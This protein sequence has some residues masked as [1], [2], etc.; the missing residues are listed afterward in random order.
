M[1]RQ[2][3]FER[4]DFTYEEKQAISAKSD[5][6]CCHCG[7]LK[8]I[9]YGATVD[10]FVPLHKGGSNQMINLV[11]LCDDC[12]QA[13]GSKI[14]PV[15][16]LP[17]LKPKYQEEL[18]GYLDSYIRSFEYIGRKQL[19]ACD[20]YDVVLLNETA[21]LASK[22]KSHAKK[23]MK[24]GPLGTK[25][26]IKIAKMDDFVKICDYYEKYLKKYGVFNSR[27]AVEANIHFWMRFGCIYYMEKAG[28]VSVMTVF[29]VKHVTNLTRSF[30]G[31]D[32]GL[33]M[34]IFSYYANEQAFSIASNIVQKFPQYIMEEQDLKLMPVFINLL[35]DDKLTG[36][37]L[38]DNGAKG[39][40]LNGGINNCLSVIIV[41]AAAKNLPADKEHE[42]TIVDGMVTPDT[43]VSTKG[44]TTDTKEQAEKEIGRT[45]EFFKAFED[46]DEKLVRYYLNH[47][48]I[49]GWIDW[50]LYD[51]LS[52]ED[53]E[54]T[55]VFEEGSEMFEHNQKELHKLA[56]CNMN[57]VA[58]AI[59]GARNDISQEVERE[60]DTV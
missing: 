56:L 19:F 23:L 33:N 57:S 3:L 36:M 7:A 10:H 4:D 39:I 38:S 35:E 29:T 47:Q 16:Y 12:N 34:Y 8:Y 46:I 53:I 5:D 43:I 1:K 30:D 41:M 6:R 25:Y 58:K 22:R 42:T 31:L 13:K 44:G 27:E 32:Y 18:D 59:R 24:A 50:M 15:S 20:E 54:R 40:H 51:I 45:I 48:D 60:D 52:C 55:G 17:Y 9:G 14:M 49:S 11:M 28:E 21:Y 37:L 26:K 2:R